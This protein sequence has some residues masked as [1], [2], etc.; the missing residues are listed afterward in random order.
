MAFPIFAPL[1]V[2][3]TGDRV[4]SL[5]L[6]TYSVLP[7]TAAATGEGGNGS[8]YNTFIL[9]SFGEK[10]QRIAPTEVSGISDLPGWSLHA[11]I[12]SQTDDIAEHDLRPLP[13]QVA[14]DEAAVDLEAVCVKHLHN[15]K[16]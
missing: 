15:A 14:L 5:L 10:L 8:Q 2:D 16:G 9:Q 6:A 1:Y 3:S 11:K 12:R 7:V 4:V 13:R